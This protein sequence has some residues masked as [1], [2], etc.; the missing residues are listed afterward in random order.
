MICTSA[1]DVGLTLGASMQVTTCMGEIM[2]ATT[3]AHQ[4]LPVKDLEEDSLRGGGT[5]LGHKGGDREGGVPGEHGMVTVDNR[6][7]VKDK[8]VGA[9]VELAA[10]VLWEVGVEV[11]RVRVAEVAEGKPDR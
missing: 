10:V 5:M 8:T 7:K 2:T 1:F 6:H 3:V 11:V 9:A 4:D